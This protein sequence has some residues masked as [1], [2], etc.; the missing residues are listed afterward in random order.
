VEC[1][2]GSFGETGTDGN[3]VQFARCTSCMAGTY[4]DAA[5]LLA[6]KS[7]EAGKFGGKNDSGKT[8]ENLACS[9]QEAKNRPNIDW[10]EQI[11]G[12]IFP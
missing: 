3:G 11:H 2:T 1:A 4:A 5:G 9:T 7:C 8:A 6:C 12:G 10:Q